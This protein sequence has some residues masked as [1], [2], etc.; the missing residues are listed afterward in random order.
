MEKDK[1]IRAKEIE[2]IKTVSIE[3]VRQQVQR[4][5]KMNI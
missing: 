3:Q 4:H 1:I 5:G 2:A